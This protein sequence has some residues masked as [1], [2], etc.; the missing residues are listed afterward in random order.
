MTM[1]KF[2]TPNGVQRL[3]DGAFIPN[4][5][6]NADWRAFLAWEAAGNTPHEADYEAP[7]A[8]QPL[9]GPK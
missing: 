2:N 4:D 6:R 5:E 9:P 8:K 1:Y 3:S 7:T